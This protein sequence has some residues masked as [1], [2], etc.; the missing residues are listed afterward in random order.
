MA[1]APD[2]PNVCEHLSV[3]SDDVSD[4][5]AFRWVE[6]GVSGLAQPR[7]WD[8]V[9]ATTCAAGG[10]R[11]AFV[12]LADGRTLA[13]EGDAPDAVPCAVTALAGEVEAPYRAVAQRR[14]GDT[15]A[16]GAVAIEL[17]ELPAEIVG[18]E[19]VLT[20]TDSGEELVVDGR[21]LEGGATELV[22]SLGGRYESYV[23]RARHLDGPLWEVD[24]DPL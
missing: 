6:S 11:C 17:A 9:V 24:V 20:V 18:E 21:Q 14:S 16:V 1:I 5:R 19:L 2:E 7:E 4:P 15:W 12:C 22:N 13:V 23:V 8:A 3:S 10:S